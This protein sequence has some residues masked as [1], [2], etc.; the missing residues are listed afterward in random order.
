MIYLLVIIMI[1]IFVFGVAIEIARNT[2]SHEWALE[3]EHNGESV[4]LKW[5]KCRKCG[6]KKTD[7]WYWKKG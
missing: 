7:S 1:I 4:R 3:Q 2:C 5:S 6:E